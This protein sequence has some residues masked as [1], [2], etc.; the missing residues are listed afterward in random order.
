MCW[1]STFYTPFHDPLCSGVFCLGVFSLDTGC[2]SDRSS[3]VV[4]T[5]ASE[6]FSEADILGAKH[7]LAVIVSLRISCWYRIFPWATHCEFG[8]GLLQ[9]GYGFL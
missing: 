6:G 7:T 4:K 9:L 1:F 8:F 2:N 3:S 5:H